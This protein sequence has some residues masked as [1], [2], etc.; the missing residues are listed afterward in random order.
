MYK[1]A[2]LLDPSD[3]EIARN[4]ALTRLKMGKKKKRRR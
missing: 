3:K 2:K 1:N 4:V